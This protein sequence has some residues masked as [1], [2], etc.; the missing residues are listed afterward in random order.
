MLRAVASCANEAVD[1]LALPAARRQI[2]LQRVVQR[3]GRI[4]HI[5][6]RDLQ[7]ELKLTPSAR[8]AALP[9]EVPDEA[10]EVESV[11]KDLSA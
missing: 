11:G 4:L 1:A 3:Y 9:P 5:G 8:D 6:L 7:K 2:A 10:P